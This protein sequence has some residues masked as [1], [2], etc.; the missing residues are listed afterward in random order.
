MVTNGDSSRN[1]GHV[2]ITICH[3][4]SP[5]VTICHHDY[6]P[7]GDVLILIRYCMLVILVRGQGK[8]FS[9]ESGLVFDRS[10]L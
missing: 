2:T 4:M 8:Q 7:M 1:F 6:P 5:F 9:L 3:H 10:N